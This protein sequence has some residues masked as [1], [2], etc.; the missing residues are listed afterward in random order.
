MP[1]AL[2]ESGK[3]RIFVQKGEPTFI[4]KKGGFHE[5]NFL[6]FNNSG[7]SIRLWGNHRRGRRVF[8]LVPS[9]EPRT[10]RQLT[11]PRQLCG[12]LKERVEPVLLFEQ[13]NR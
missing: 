6:N 4:E 7:F 13:A 3:R 12:D 1:Y 2:I 10:G 9:R 8:R 11:L 5:T